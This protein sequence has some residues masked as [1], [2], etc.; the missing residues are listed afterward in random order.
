MD[1]VEEARALIRQIRAQKRVDENGG[2]DQ[3]A[4][5]LEEAL[6]VMSTQLYSKPT[7]FLLELIQNA[8]DNKYAPGTTPQLS[9]IYRRDGYLWV[10]CNELGFSAGNVHAI[11]R[12]SAST[13]KVIEGSQKGYIG[14]KVRRLGRRPPH[15]TATML[16]MSSTSSLRANLFANNL[17]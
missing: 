4:N 11:C 6:N 14:E 17:C 3:N 5:D 9:I 15:P 13:K 7:H 12:I 10:G 16:R 2:N 1:S 8:D